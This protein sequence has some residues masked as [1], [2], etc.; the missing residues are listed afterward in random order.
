[1]NSP[2]LSP[3]PSSSLA[4]RFSLS[5]ALVGLIWLT[6]LAGHFTPWLEWPALFV[7]VAGS[8]GLVLFLG[9]T[10][11]GRQ[12]IWLAGGNAGRSLYW[13][14]LAGAVLFIMDITN[15]ILYYKS[16]GAPMVE[17][18]RLLV[19]RS[20]LYLFPI[21]ILAEEFLWRGVMFSSLIEKGVNPHLTVL[22]TTILYALNHFAV[23]PVGMRERALMAMMAVPIGVLG[24]YL[25]LK[26]R[27][28][29]GSV[30]VHMIT[31]VSMVLDIFVIP[32]LLFNP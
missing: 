26:T 14:T 30:I 16:G 2:T 15:T 19:H 5:F 11:T 8:L 31:M 3:P 12:E 21:L 23:A 1:M 9:R 29:W 17:M 25:V 6:G 4:L 28:V 27:N 22:L 24:G 7:Y 18:E 32:Q 10:G 20:L 13:G